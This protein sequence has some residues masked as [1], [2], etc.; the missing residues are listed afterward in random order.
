MWERVRCELSNSVHSLTQPPHSCRPCAIRPSCHRRLDSS[1]PPVLSAHRPLAGQTILGAAPLAA[2]P[3]ASHGSDTARHATRM[4]EQ[5]ATLDDVSP[6]PRTPQPP[7]IATT[8]GGPTQERE[9]VTGG[10]SDDDRT[11][12]ICFASGDDED[13]RLIAP[14]RCSGTVSSPPATTAWPSSILL[15]ER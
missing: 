1:I 13:G 15:S 14:C 3:V 8:D 6:P 4:A 2:V 10:D 7:V 11:C 5:D 12:R 9:P